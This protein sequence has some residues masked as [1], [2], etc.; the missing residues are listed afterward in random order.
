MKNRWRM[1]RYRQWEK[2]MVRYVSN[3]SLDAYKA[4]VT[5]QPYASSALRLAHRLLKQQR[6]GM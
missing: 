5:L 4:S 1:W 6:G 2:R 3:N